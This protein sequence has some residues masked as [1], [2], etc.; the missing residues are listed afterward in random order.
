MRARMSDHT[1]AAPPDAVRH[2][3]GSALSCDRAAEIHGHGRPVWAAWR[4]PQVRKRY[5][6]AAD[7]PGPPAIAGQGSACSSRVTAS[8]RCCVASCATSA[9]AALSPT[10]PRAA[11]GFIASTV[12]VP[13]PLS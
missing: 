13:S 10:M 3:L 4:Y 6:T 7:G 9:I 11:W 5:T 2:A 1:A 12:L 8:C